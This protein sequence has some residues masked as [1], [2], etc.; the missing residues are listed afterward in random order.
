MRK[1][2][3]CSIHNCINN[4]N[5]D[6]CF[7]WFIS[8]ESIANKFKMGTIKVEV[9]EPGFEDITD[10]STGTYTKNVQVAS[11]GTKKNLCKDQINSRME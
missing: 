6:G 9:L 8:T 3:N 7:A 5:F 10:V 11:L 2:N 4:F 1:K